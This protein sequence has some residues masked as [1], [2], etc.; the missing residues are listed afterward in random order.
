MEHVLTLV[1]K[2]EGTLA[3]EALAAQMERLRSLGAETGAPE[4]L[5]PGRAA[6]IPF[7]G[8]ATLEEVRAAASPLHGA[9]LDYCVQPARARRKKLLIADMDSTIITVEC[10]DEI[11]DFAGLKAEVSEITERA[12][13]GELDFPGALRARAAMLEGLDAAV[14]ERAYTERVRLTPGAAELVR[15]MTRHGAYA[16]LVSGGFT[17]FTERVRRAAGFD[18]DQANRLVLRDGRLTGAV[19]EPILDSS[20]KLAALDRLAREQGV[21]P[22]WTLA[23]GDGANDIPMIRAAGLGVAFHAKRRAAEAADAEV[24]FGDLTTVLYYQGYRQ[25]EIRAKSR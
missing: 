4:M 11:A 16:A 23:V 25:H 21:E 10:I 17:F 5:A 13:R 9:G 7:D 20:A 6:D 19:E 3:P 18:M 24:R 8:P 1:G 2:S 15:T 22:D 14:L 12:M